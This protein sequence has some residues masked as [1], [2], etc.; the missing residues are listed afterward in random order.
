M[1]PTWLNGDVVGEGKLVQSHTLTGKHVVETTFNDC[2]F[3]LSENQRADAVGIT[4][5]N[6][7]KS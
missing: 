2:R 1:I 5:S 6:N 3:A 7:S 4:E